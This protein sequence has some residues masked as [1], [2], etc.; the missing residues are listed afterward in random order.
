MA[1][2]DMIAEMRGCV[3]NYSASLARIHLRNSWTDIRNL[4]GW[5]FQVGNSGFSTPGLMNAGSGYGD[6]RFQL[7]H[8]RRRCWKRGM[9]QWRSTSV[10]LLTQRQFRVGASIYSSNIIAA[11]FSSR[12]P[13]LC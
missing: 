8:W 4:K 5:S 2:S 12:Q 9:G 1:L 11:D 3:P 7:R 13:L 6:A 10:S